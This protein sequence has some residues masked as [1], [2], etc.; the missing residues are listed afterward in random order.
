VLTL[1]ETFLVSVA[2]PEQKRLFEAFG[3]ERVP[4]AIGQSWVKD[5]PIE[6][7][8]LEL[9]RTGLEV[10]IEAVM[11]GRRPPRPRSPDPLEGAV[12]AA[13][14]HWH[15]PGWLE[16]SPL[17]ASVE[18]AR[19]APGGQGAE[20][21]RRALLGALAAAGA[22]SGPDRALALRAVE[23]AYIRNGLSHEAAAEPLAVSRTTAYRL[24]KRGVQALAEELSRG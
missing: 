16:R 4:G 19:L 15:E 9:S 20:S 13:L 17:A 2:L 12:R 10:W 1:G 3:F 21:V 7:F 18:V 22:R 24:L 8:L 6:G 11:A 5:Q 14:L 23:L